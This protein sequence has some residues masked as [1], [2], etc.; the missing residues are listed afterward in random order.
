MY[1]CDG[2]NFNNG[3]FKRENLLNHSTTAAH[4]F[5]HT[6]GLDHP[7]NL[8]IRGKGTPGIMYPRGTLVDPQFQYYP[9]VAPGEKGGTLNP[10]TRKV[11]QTDIDDLHLDKLDFDKSGLAMVGGFTSMWHEKH[12]S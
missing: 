4:E 10:F 2:I 6:I 9:D 5:G 7:H 3:Y 11:L 8:D 1:F 12:M